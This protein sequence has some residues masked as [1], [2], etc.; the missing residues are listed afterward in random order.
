L[1]PTLVLCAKGCDRQGKN[2]YELE[3]TVNV[4]SVFL[5][6]GVQSARP[7]GDKCL[8]SPNPHCAHAEKVASQQ[9]REEGKKLASPQRGS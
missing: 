8:Q 6:G 3:A 2:K 1:T 5:R 4:E 9:H 7:F